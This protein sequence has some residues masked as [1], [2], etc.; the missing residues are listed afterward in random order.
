MQS[1]NSVHA[2]HVKKKRVGKACDSCRIKKTKCDGK[3]PCNR[4]LLDNKI[5][6]FTE[7][8]KVK[9]KIHPP[10]YIEL[11]ETRLDILS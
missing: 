7:K 2:C 9:E 11:L 6:V 1:E 3:K 8:R 4:C 5:C 10:G